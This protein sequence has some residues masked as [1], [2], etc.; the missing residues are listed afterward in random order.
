VGIIQRAI[1]NFY[2][3]FRTDLQGNLCIAPIAGVLPVH[4]FLTTA[5]DGTGSPQITGNYAAASTDFYYTNTSATPFT[6]QTALLSIADATT[7]DQADYGGITG[8]ITNGVLLLMKNPGGTEVPLYSGTAFKTNTNW[9]SVTSHVILSRFPGTPQTLSISFD[10]GSDFG[11]P[12]VLATGWSFI[13]RAHDNFTGLLSQTV[14]L[15][16]TF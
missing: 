7:M 15:Q 12:L 5:G 9:L 6:V 1:D 4:R 11:V 3:D 10:L 2:H 8:G 13:F 14:A 16:G